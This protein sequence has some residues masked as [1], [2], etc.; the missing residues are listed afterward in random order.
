MG[1]QKRA[2]RWGAPK[3]KADE[4][5]RERAALNRARELEVE[6]QNVRNNE[7]ALAEALT[8]ANARIGVL[9]KHEAAAADP[10]TFLVK[11]TPAVQHV[12]SELA[13]GGYYPNT[14]PATIEEIVRIHVRDLVATG[15]VPRW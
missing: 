2:P 9:N 5:S 1:R 12:L 8:N 7:R 15:K 14:V 10:N 3:K 13:T 6:L 4:Y 11:V